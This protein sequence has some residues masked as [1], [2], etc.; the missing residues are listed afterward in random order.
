MQLAAPLL[1]LLVTS[2]ATVD[3]KDGIMDIVK[4]C[5]LFLTHAGALPV[6]VLDG[7]S[8]ALQ[9]ESDLCRLIGRYGAVHSFFSYTRRCL[10]ELQ[11][12]CVHHMFVASLPYASCST[13]LACSTSVV[14]ACAVYTL[15]CCDDTHA[16][17]ALIHPCIVLL[18][19]FMSRR[20]RMYSAAADGTL[21]H[22]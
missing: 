5:E 15:F 13:A 19:L 11:C 6:R 9:H 12:I 2:V 1:L 20:L 3:A 10:A 22:G 17:N 18:T 8:T 7:V 14:C 21:C 4:V 16:Y